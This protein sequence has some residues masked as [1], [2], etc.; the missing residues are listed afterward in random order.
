MQGLA[1]LHAE[2]KDDDAAEVEAALEKSI[3]RGLKVA[4]EKEAVPAPKAKKKAARQAIAEDR[5]ITAEPSSDT[6]VDESGKSLSE[7]S[8]QSRARHAN[9]R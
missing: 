8:V 6:A 2:G 5:E 4:V 3:E 9:A 7:V 1:K